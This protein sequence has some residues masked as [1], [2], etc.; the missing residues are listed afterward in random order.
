ML[1][2]IEISDFALIEYIEIDFKNGLT[3]LTGETGAG[4]SIIIDSISALLGNRVNKEMIRERCDLAVITGYFEITQIPE[5]IPKL[6]NNA[7]PISDGSLV[8]TREIYTSGKTIARINNKTVSISLLKEITAFLLDI[9]GQNENQTI[10]SPETQLELLDR[11]AGEPVRVLLNEYRQALHEYKDCLHSMSGYLTDDD[12]K[13]QILELLEYQMNEI[14]TTHPKLGEDEDLKARKAIL[15]NAFK[16][17]SALKKVYEYLNGMESSL[18]ALAAVSESRSLIQQQLSGIDEYQQIEQE[19]SEVEYQLEAVCEKVKLHMDKIE[20]YP[21]ETEELDERLDQLFR[22]KSKYGGS[23][24]SVIQFYKESA[25]RVRDIQE[26][27]YQIECLK[28]K[29]DETYNR[30]REISD[31]LFQERNRAARTLE[32]TVYSELSELGMQ[33]TS[34]YVRIEHPE[35]PS[36]FPFS[37]IDQIGFFISPNAGEGLKPLSLIASGGE[38]SRIMIAIKTI[39]A[40]SDRIPSL[41]FDEVDT[42]ISG[43][44]A[45]LLGDKLTKLSKSHQIF[46][47]THMAQIAAKARNHIYIEKVVHFDRTIVTVSYLDGDQRAVEIARLLSGEKNRDKALELAREMLGVAQSG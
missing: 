45:G 2:R 15:S 23:I 43:K 12:K 9:H 6:Q 34:F 4:K 46:C 21:G 17:S 3:I 7:L 16:I 8:I 31:H 36:Q 1:S 44:T 10:F 38:A 40:H 26:S 33:G 32:E 18:P 11:F 27:E 22:L 47:V 19:L 20:L 35:N 42:G 30:L 28:K 29:K 25:K 13:N 39:L 5:I 41:V 24:E 37:G 14:R